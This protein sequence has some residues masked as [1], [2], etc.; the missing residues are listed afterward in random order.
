MPRSTC[1][2]CQQVQNFTQRSPTISGTLNGYDVALA[3]CDACGFVILAYFTS[4]DARIVHHFPREMRCM[5]C[6]AALRS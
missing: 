3:Q 5:N 2:N 4:Q 1:P 6:E